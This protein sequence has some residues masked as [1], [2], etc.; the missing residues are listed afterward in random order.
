MATVVRVRHNSDVCVKADNAS[1][2]PTAEADQSCAFVGRMDVIVMCIHIGSTGSLRGGIAQRL[3][4]R[5]KTNCIAFRVL[6][7]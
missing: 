6:P 2:Q 5:V 3:F 1:H 4:H 7:Y